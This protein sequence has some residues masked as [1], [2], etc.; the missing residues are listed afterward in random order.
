ML[1]DHE[2]FKQGPLPIDLKQTRKYVTPAGWKDEVEAK[3]I[4]VLPLAVKS[5]QIPRRRKGSPGF[6]YGIYAHD[7]EECPDLEVLCGGVNSKTAKA[8]AIWRQ[9][10]LLHF[11]FAHSPADLNENGRAMLV[12]SI[13]YIARFTEDRPIART[14][15]KLAGAAPYNRKM[16]HRILNRRTRPF[17]SLDNNLGFCLSAEAMDALAGHDKQQIEAWYQDVGPYIHADEK[18]KLT[19]DEEAKSFGVPPATPEFFRTAID[20]LRSADARAITARQLLARYAPDGPGREQDAREWDTWWSG[21]KPYL[22]FSDTGGY[23][24]YID[25]LA[26]KRGVPSV[27]LRGPRRATLR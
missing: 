14:P 16:I 2:A 13:A 17:V 7:Y 27:E 26:K 5:K 15:S 23:R 3:L 24:W 8:G 22:F 10:N 11:G 4:E 9:G 12:N 19:V 25:P 1:R 20:A 6:G 21:H 18:G